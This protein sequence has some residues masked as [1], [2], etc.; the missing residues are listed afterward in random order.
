MVKE[1]SQKCPA[2]QGSPRA[3]P[4]GSN[5]KECR[6]PRDRVAHDDSAHVWLAQRYRLPPTLGTKP[7]D[8]VVRMAT[9]CA[10]LDHT[11]E[12]ERGIGTA[13]RDNVQQLLSSLAIYPFTE[14]L[15]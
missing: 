14:F 11:D 6:V 4:D 12:R 3:T 5:V 7:H 1:V 13:N 8:R 15:G 9:V 2:V 10:D